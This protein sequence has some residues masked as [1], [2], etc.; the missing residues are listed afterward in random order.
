MLNVLISLR[1]DFSLQL[2]PS[3]AFAID[4]DTGIVTVKNV[5]D[6]E[7]LNARNDRTYSVN[8]SATVS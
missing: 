4:P 5:L 1:S 7:L 6:Y 3:F 2:D 8:I